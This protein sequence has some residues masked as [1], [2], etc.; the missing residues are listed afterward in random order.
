MSDNCKNPRCVDG[1]VRCN[2]CVSDCA[3]FCEECFPD[4]RGSGIE[5]ER[6]EVVEGRL[7]FDE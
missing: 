3:D 7:D 1:I 4:R 6:G 2:Q 5:L